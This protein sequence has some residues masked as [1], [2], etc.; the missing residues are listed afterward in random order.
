M[1]LLTLLPL[2]YARPLIQVEDFFE[3]NKWNKNAGQK[4]GQN[5][6]QLDFFATKGMPKMASMTE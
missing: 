2:V 3:L 4:T 1:F 5:T 6:P